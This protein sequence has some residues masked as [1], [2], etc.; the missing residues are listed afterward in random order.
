MPSREAGGT[1]FLPWC[2]EA[3]CF[4]AW[5]NRPRLSVSTSGTE[6]TNLQW[7]WGGLAFSVLSLSQKTQ[8]VQVPLFIKAIKPKQLSHGVLKHRA[9]QNT[10]GRLQVTVAGPHTDTTRLIQTSRQQL[11]S[12][13]YNSKP[14]CSRCLVYFLKKDRDGISAKKP[15]SFP[16]PLNS[17]PVIN[18]SSLKGQFL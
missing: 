13:H 2:R 8:Y 10:I 12:S 7:K 1:S 5:L 3:S 6:Q 15:S 17:F 16:E 14:C 18:L 4:A 9:S 11:H